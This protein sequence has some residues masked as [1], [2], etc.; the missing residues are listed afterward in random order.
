MK[1]WVQNKYDLCSSEEKKTFRLERRS[2]YEDVSSEW[3]WLVAA[4]VAKQKAFRLKK[5]L[6]YKN[7][8]L[9]NEFWNNGSLLLI[10][11]YWMDY[12][13][14]AAV[15]RCE[16]K[17]GTPTSNHAD[18]RNSG[19]QLKLHEKELKFGWENWSSSKRRF[20]LQ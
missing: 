16:H 13:C 10:W 7:L 9:Q 8:R 12:L 17:K 15:Y 3:I 2:S 6:S 4:T 19:Q 1:M 11:H 5:R 18:W 20:Y 14:K